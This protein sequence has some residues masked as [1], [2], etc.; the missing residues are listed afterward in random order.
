MTQI[1]I[2]GKSFHAG[3]FWNWSSSLKT[4]PAF[5]WSLKSCVEVRIT[6]HITSAYT[7]FFQMTHR[8]HTLIV[9][10]DCLLF[11]QAPFLHT[12][13]TEGTLMSW[14]PV[15][16][17]GTLLK[18]LTSY[19]QKV[20]QHSNCYQTPQRIV[21]YFAMVTVCFSAGIAHRDLKLENILCEYTDRVSDF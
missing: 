7:Y 16:W 13:R 21:F 17:S 9:T 14:R 15:R 4:T 2:I 3:T 20:G 6:Q 1:L 19:T 11:L 10:S 12:S 18:L 8:K 5:I